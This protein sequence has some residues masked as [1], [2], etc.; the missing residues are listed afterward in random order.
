MVSNLNS[1]SVALAILCVFLSISPAI[2]LL[3]TLPP[4]DNPSSIVS[5]ATSLV[6]AGLV[7][8]GSK[9]SSKPPCAL[10]A[11]I[12]SEIL[13]TSDNSSPLLNISAASSGVI[14]FSLASLCI[15]RFTTSWLT[16]LPAVLRNTE[17]KPDRPFPI[18]LM[19]RSKAAVVPADTEAAPPIFSALSDQPPSPLPRCAADPWAVPI[20][21][22]LATRGK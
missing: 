17:S 20:P 21:I 22:T 3:L 13:G 15:S 8:K 12:S 7:L 9:T 2:P 18:P 19:P 6:R 10:I 11:P 5:R 16:L 4:G 1:S 14:L